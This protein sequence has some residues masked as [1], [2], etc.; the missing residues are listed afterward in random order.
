MLQKL[1]NAA[2]SITTTARS[3]T[4]KAP[5]QSP[6]RNYMCYQDGAPFMI[7]NAPSLL[8]AQFIVAG[9]TQDHSWLLMEMDK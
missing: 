6:Y 8:H 3:F 9:F 2:V 7:I 1:R 4:A 5:R